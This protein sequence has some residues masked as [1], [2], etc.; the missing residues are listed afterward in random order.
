MAAENTPP[1]TGSPFLDSLLDWAL[2]HRW[3]ELYD[4]VGLV[5]TLAG[6]GFILYGVYTSRTAAQ[7]A[8]R[9]AKQARSE[10]FKLD[11]VTQL[12]EALFALEEIKRLHRDSAW[13]LLPERYNKLRT[14]LI[15][16]R[17]GRSD[18]LEQQKAIL[19]KAIQD[20]KAMEEKIDRTLEAGSD[21]PSVAKLNRVISSNIDN[22]QELLA[23]LKVNNR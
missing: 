10:I 15:V 13:S 7:E 9:A 22:I 3:I 1:S 4:P 16:V 14:A 20:L 6:F 2:S 23:N 19:Q 11:T 8:E 17:S 21:S 18:M 5:L 12:T